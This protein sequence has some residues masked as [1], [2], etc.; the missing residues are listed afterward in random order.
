MPNTAWGQVWQ[1]AS[2]ERI[3]PPAKVWSSDEWERIRLGF[4]PREMEDKWNAYVQDK[5]LALQ[6]SWT[7]LVVYVAH[8]APVRDGWQIVEARV[9][10]DPAAYDRGSDD[11]ET[12]KLEALIEGVV[13]KRWADDAERLKPLRPELPPYCPICG[14]R[15]GTGTLTMMGPRMQS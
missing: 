13:L 2:W 3:P 9:A 5:A 4:R 15:M 11:Y 10:D 7:G 6:R 12:L 1:P 8:F 14:I